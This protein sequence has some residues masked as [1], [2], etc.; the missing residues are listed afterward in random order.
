GG[1]LRALG[2]D[3]AGWSR[4]PKTLPGFATYDGAEGL[5][6]LAA[7]SE[8]LVSLLPATPATEGILDAALFAQLPPGAMLVN[9]GR[10]RHLVEPHRPAARAGGRIGR[11]VPAVSRGGPRPP[12]H[13]S[14]HHPR[15]V[16]T[17]HAAA[18]P[19]PPT[20]LPIIAAA[21]ARFEAGLPLAD[22]VDPVRGY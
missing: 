16:V 14:W 17:P 8:I 19:H 4:T 22:L 5:A 12:T 7:R 21:L 11:G 10:G 9:A 13:P 20:A 2:F 18:E 15:V 6:A 3:V 1:K